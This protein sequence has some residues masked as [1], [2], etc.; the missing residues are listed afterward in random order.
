MTTYGAL[1]L[2][3][4]AAMLIFAILTKKSFEALL[5]GT[6]V[7]Y[8]IMY[9][10]NFLGPWCD[11]LID[12]ISDPDNQYIL[13]LCGLFGGFIFLLREANG[14]MGFSNLVAR[15]CKGERS[16]MITSF[17]MGIAIFADDY[18]NIMTIGTCM[19][20]VCDKRKVPRQALAYIIDSTGAP[21]CALIPFSTWVVFYS[22]VFMQEQAIVDMGYNTEMGIYLDVLP[23]MFYP[24]FALLIVF[25][26]AVGIMPKFGAMKKAYAN[27]ESSGLEHKHPEMHN[28]PS[29]D[30]AMAGMSVDYPPE[31]SKKNGNILDFLI[32]IMVLITMTLITGE[33]LQAIIITLAVCMIMYL[34]RKK[35]TFTRYVELFFAGFADIL[36][37]LGILLASF[38]IKN[39]CAEMGLSEYV[40]EK[41]MPFLNSATLAAVIFVI[42]AVLTFITSS[43]WGIEAVAVS[44]VVPLASALGANV[45]L[46]LGAVVS[47]GVFGSHACFYSDATVLSSA[48]CEIDNMSHAVSQIPYAL[49][50]AALATITFLVFGFIM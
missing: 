16:V 42:I 12:T 11:L 19:K 14:T 45:L 37:V 40:I 13:L 22:G 8:I 23:Y 25:L 33:M 41:A 2:I 29:V 34:P 7:A 1:C 27:V 5:F 35:M 4:P 39:A 24:I 32:P 43:F 17:L 31:K 18:L 36:P 6:I 50:S 26:F 46:V 9:K 15:F 10:Q 28:V 3:P 38:M 21:V 20:D 30:I 47:G 48:T 49:I 44:I